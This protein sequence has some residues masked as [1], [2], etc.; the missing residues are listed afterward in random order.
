MTKIK[1]CGLFRDCDIDY[2]N[3]TLPDYCGFII[4]FPKSHRSIDKDK[5]ARLISGLNRK[6]K[7]VCVFVDADIDYIAKFDNL[8]DIIQLHGNESN[9]YISELNL[10]LPDKEIWKAYKVKNKDDIKVAKAAAA[11]LILLDNGYGTGEQ[12]DWSLIDGLGRDF[13]LAGGVDVGNLEK[14]MKNYL[15][16]CVDVSSGVETDKL[17]DFNKIKQI[18]DTIRKEE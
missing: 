15:P 12:F 6:I 9:D 2:V 3:L 14:A 5:A 8:C 1:I 10:R 11:D 7:S 4:D 18:V 13:I 16:Y 17:K